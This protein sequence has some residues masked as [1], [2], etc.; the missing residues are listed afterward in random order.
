[1]LPCSCLLSLRL[2][3][4]HR[5]FEWIDNIQRLAFV[6]IPIR[7]RRDTR[8]TTAPRCRYGRT[9]RWTETPGHIAKI[10]ATS[11]LGWHCWQQWLYSVACW[12]AQDCSYIILPV[13]RNYRST[14]A[15]AI[16]VTTSCPIF[17]PGHISSTRQPLRWWKTLAQRRRQPQRAY[18]PA[19]CE[20]KLLNCI[21]VNSAHCFHIKLEKYYQMKY[22]K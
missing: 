19:G 9:S 14:P 20:I 1:M 21:L 17:P 13:V 15:Y 2:F 22:L 10:G 8:W 12:W 16:I 5:L 7:I 6:A 3:F 11:S 4:V 18:L